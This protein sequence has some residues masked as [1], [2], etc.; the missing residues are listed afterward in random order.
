MKRNVFLKT[1]DEANGCIRYVVTEDGEPYFTG[2]YVPGVIN[3]GDI[4][5]VRIKDKLPSCNAVFC[6]AGDI[7]SSFISDCRYEPGKMLLAQAES[8]GHDSKC[9]RF[10]TDIKLTGEYIVLLFRQEPCRSEYCIKFSKNIDDKEA[11]NRIRERILMSANGNNSSVPKGCDII[12]R[13]SAASLSDLSVIDDE[14][15]KLTAEFEILRFTFENEFLCNAKTG[16]LYG[17]A[18]VLEHIIRQTNTSEFDEIITDSSLLSH[19]LSLK[20]INLSGRIKCMSKS[21]TFDIFDVYSIGSKLAQ[22]LRHKV[23]MKSGSFLVIDYTEA[24]TVIDVNS[25]KN[26]SGN[27]IDINYE[28]AREISRQLRLRD[29]GG[30][31]ICDFINM[32]N[33]SDDNELLSYLKRI[34]A[35][36]P[37]P[38]VISGMTKLGLVE[39][40]RKRR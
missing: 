2:V 39:L 28:A 26:T 6:D 29:I 32:K 8:L 1:R 13:T 34:T 37:S 3:T 10:S 36:D 14:L 4:C 27:S 33:K 25:G 7:R 18:D 30:I 35:S 12:I 9:I 11:R 31:V 21:N 20:H 15:K 40:T 19:E 16:I 24:L 23:Y 38:V 22:L 5:S 17:C